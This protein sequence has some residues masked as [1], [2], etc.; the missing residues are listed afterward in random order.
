MNPIN[1]GRRARASNDR[2]SVDSS[3]SS[4]TGLNIAAEQPARSTTRSP[5]GSSQEHDLYATSEDNLFHPDAGS[6]TGINMRLPGQE[7]GVRL[8]HSSGA[9][10]SIEPSSARIF[11]S[12]QPVSRALV[13]LPG[14]RTKTLDHL[15]VPTPIQPTSIDDYAT[16]A[17]QESA[18]LTV[19]LPGRDQ[20]VPQVTL[21]HTP[22]APLVRATSTGTLFSHDTNVSA[23]EEARIHLPGHLLPRNRAPLATET[24]SSLPLEAPEFADKPLVHLPVTEAGRISKIMAAYASA[25]EVPLH[26]RSGLLYE[27]HFSE[28]SDEFIELGITNI[29]DYH[30]LAQKFFGRELGGSL[31]QFTNVVRKR[32]YRYDSSL[33]LLGCIDVPHQADE[34]SRRIASL[35]RPKFV[36]QDRVQNSHNYVDKLRPDYTG[37]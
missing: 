36:T 2:E 14:A 6:P 16:L 1:Q 25:R 18:R 15:S 24:Q 33:Q 7:T 17:I 12:S 22:D 34:G 27:T 5:E 21:G 26:W 29:N 35:F 9:P 3:E 13:N 30:T 31:E 23:P 28:H 11:T 8:R 10:L 20:R 37:G 4:A 19:Q 32:V